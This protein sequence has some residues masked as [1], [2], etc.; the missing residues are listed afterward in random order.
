MLA[1]TPS[2]LFQLFSQSIRLPPPAPLDV[3]LCR[4]SLWDTKPG[5]PNPHLK[6]WHAM[7]LSK[8]CP[9]I[10]PTMSEVWA[11]IMKL[12]VYVQ[13]L[14]LKTP[15]LCTLLSILLYDKQMFFFQNCKFTPQFCV[16]TI[17]TSKWQYQHVES[18]ANFSSTQISIRR[19]KRILYGMVNKT[20]AQG[21]TIFYDSQAPLLKKALNG[22]GLLKPIFYQCL[23]NAHEMPTFKILWS[24]RF[25]YTSK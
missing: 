23:S 18:K 5:L 1:S 15:I 12:S 25:Y 8:H 21:V 4:H 7:W 17:I 22:V 20:T 14:T 11:E 19:W 10:N 13:F 24:P 2:L 16:R 3:I 9:C 6:I